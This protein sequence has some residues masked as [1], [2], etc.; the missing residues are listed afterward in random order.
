ML[1]SGGTLILT[2]NSAAFGREEFRAMVKEESTISGEYE[3]I[4]PPSDYAV[5][6]KGKG[7]KILRIKTE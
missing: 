6:D 3:F 5:R 1:A 7:L 2:L 4:E